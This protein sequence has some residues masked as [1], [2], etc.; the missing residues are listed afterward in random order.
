MKEYKF[1][2]DE[3]GDS[4]PK[5]YAQSPFFIVTGCA[6]PRN[7]QSAI[8]RNLDQ[9]RYKYGGVNWQSIRFHSSVIGAKFGAWR[10]LKDQN[11][12]QEFADDILWAVRESQIEIL[13]V[14]VDKSQLIPTSW[15]ARTVYRKVFRKLLYSYI[16]FLE[17]KN[18]H[19]DVVAEASKSSQDIMLYQQ[20]FHFQ[21]N[22]LSELGLSHQV[23]KKR[24][25]GLSFVTKH[26]HDPEEE[27]A[28]LLAYAVRLKHE[29][30]KGLRLKSKLTPYQRAV[31][32]AL[33]MKLVRVP[34]YIDRRKK[35]IAAALCPIAFLP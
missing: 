15:Q 9:L 26:N 1:F 35:K 4:N 30:S 32:K 14:L 2:L 6:I 18:A 11:K 8:A 25:T 31:L 17:L 29:I 5:T 19:S 21:T 27:V 10:F 16:C 3:S 33:D 13:S 22:G 20:F 34:P 7:N 24:L 23:V 12:E 28:D